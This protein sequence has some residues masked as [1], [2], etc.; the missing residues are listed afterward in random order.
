MSIAF[1][2]RVMV[3]ARIAFDGVAL[4]GSVS[5]RRTVHFSKPITQ[6]T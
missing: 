6:R 5:P 4:F 1:N 3:C 2:L